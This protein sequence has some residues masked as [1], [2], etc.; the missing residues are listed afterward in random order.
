MIRR[1]PRSTLSSSSAASDVY[2]R[3]QLHS[4][5]V[6]LTMACSELV[7]GK[8]YQVSGY[9]VDSIRIRPLKPTVGQ[10]MLLRAKT[11]DMRDRQPSTSHPDPNTNPVPPPVP[12]GIAI[13]SD[14]D[15]VSCDVT[16]MCPIVGT[17]YKRKGQ[18]SNL[19]QQAWARLDDQDKPNYLF[20]EQEWDYWGQDLG[21]Q[22]GDHLPA[23]HFEIL[24]IRKTPIEICLLYT[25]P[26][27]RDS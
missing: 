13:H 4:A 23:V 26:S 22:V 17:R 1:P 3:Q 25:S 6:C 16:G 10:P 24:N 27:P 19:C 20:I 14:P 8:G 9:W 2:K 12:T 11:L 15:P 7:P 18:D 5:K 21:P